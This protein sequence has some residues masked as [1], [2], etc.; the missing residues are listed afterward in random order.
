MTNPNPNPDPNPNPSPNPDPDPDPDPDPNQAA[1]KEAPTP[2]V[3]C[4]LQELERANA[5]LAEMGRAL[6]ELE[7][8]LQ[9]A[10]N[11]SDLMEA[12]VANLTANEVPP[13]WLKICGQIG[14]TGTYNRKPLSAWFSDLLLRVK[15]LKAWLELS[16]QLDQLPRSV[17][18]AGLWNPMGYITACLQVTQ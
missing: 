18:I 9:G 1:L 13:L 7:L 10:L 16:S 6:T 15:Q 12:L 2:Y 4:A 14:P 5:V 3:V 11:I 8:G 17:W